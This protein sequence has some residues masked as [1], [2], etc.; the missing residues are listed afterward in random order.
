MYGM[1]GETEF[2]VRF[3]L[4]GIPI[5]IHPVFWL[6]SAILVWGD[7]NRMDL[8]FIGILCVLISILVHELGHALM[9]RRYGYPSEIVLYFFGGYATTSHFS[10]WKRIAVTAAGPG[11]GLV[12]FYLVYGVFT[13][14]ERQA[15]QILLEYDAIFY[16]IR[17]MLFANLVW[18]IMN[19]VPCLPLDGGQ[20]MQALVFRYG[21][22]NATDLVMRIS[23]IASGAV[24]IW[25]LYCIQQHKAG[26]PINVIPFPQW[27]IPGI[28]VMALQPHPG[29]LAFFFGY[30]CAQNLIAWNEIRR[31]W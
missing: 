30:M 5:R 20:I 16:A 31:F 26:I 17:I 2:D 4:F 7:G 23:T 24:A 3:Q 21:G 10:T 9:S 13:V 15:P 29:F 22:R 18:N 25:A 14:L 1:A 28:N 19:L 12:L 27:M 8:V 6:S 11:A